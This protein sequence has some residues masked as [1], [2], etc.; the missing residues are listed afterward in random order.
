MKQLLRFIKN[1]FWV[2]LICLIGNTCCALLDGNP[3]LN[4][5]E[6]LLGLIILIGIDVG[7][8]SYTE[9]PFWTMKDIINK[10]KKH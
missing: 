10:I 6:W 5:Y 8:I 4:C 2:F 1:L 9:E 7:I 3:D